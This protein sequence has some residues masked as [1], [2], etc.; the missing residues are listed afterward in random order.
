MK[1]NLKIGDFVSLKHDI[2]SDT[3]EFMGV[4]VDFETSLDTI[5]SIAHENNNS[6][7][8]YAWCFVA[9]CSNRLRTVLD[10]E[11]RQLAKILVQFLQTK[12]MNHDFN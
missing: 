2:V 8:T 1:H 7:A 5:I 12:D 9:N 3:S 6:H 11:N 4:I 10:V